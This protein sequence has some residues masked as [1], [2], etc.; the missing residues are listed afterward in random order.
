MYQVSNALKAA[1]SSQLLHIRICTE[2]GTEL[3]HDTLTYTASCASGTD[4]AIGSVCAA[5]IRCKL[6]GAYDLQDAPITV[7]VGA[8]VDG[9]IQYLSLIHI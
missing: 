9:A 3:D 6:Y 2:A 5:M 1:L 8:E 4:I 7:E